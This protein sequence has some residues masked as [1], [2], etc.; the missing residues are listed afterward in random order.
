MSRQLALLI[1]SLG[2]GILAAVYHERLILTGVA[3]KAP[4]VVAVFMAALFVRLARGVPTFPFEKISQ[5]N[6]EMVLESLVHLRGMYGH[7]FLSFMATL[8]ASVAY[9]PLIQTVEDTQIL[10][11]ITA[12][13]VS[14]LS[15]AMSTAYLVYRTDIA[16]FKAQTVAMHEVVS[17]IA[18]ATAAVSAETVRKSLRP[19]GP[20]DKDGV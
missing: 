10:G 14:S 8:V 5:Q 19:D 13:L 2:A 4:I 9:T 12:A 20:V 16:L 6:A 7:A 17:D 18:A 1:V 15:W 11:L 3:D